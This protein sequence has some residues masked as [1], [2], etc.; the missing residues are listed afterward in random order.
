MEAAG[1]TPWPPILMIP[2]Q[3]DIDPKIGFLEVPI[4]YD[5]IKP[6]TRVNLRRGNSLWHVIVL[7]RLYREQVGVF[8]AG[9]SSSGG[10]SKGEKEKRMLIQDMTRKMSMRLI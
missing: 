2:C 10:M 9:A 8:T 1:V 4:S 3:I 7:A 5:S 6:I